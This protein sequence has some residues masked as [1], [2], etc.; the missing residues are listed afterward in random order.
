MMFGMSFGMSM[1]TR[2]MGP[3]EVLGRRFDRAKTAR[4]RARVA[5]AMIKLGASGIEELCYRVMSESVAVGEE[6]VD[7]LVARAS[8]TEAVLHEL[9]EASQ[10]RGAARVLEEMESRRATR[11]YACCV[12][13]GNLRQ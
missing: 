3:L 8:H 6:I 2:Q 7:V 11:R 1:N 5:R 9:A 12:G 10:N 4:R 13:G